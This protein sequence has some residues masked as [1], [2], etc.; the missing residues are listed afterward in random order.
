MLIY[1]FSF[2]YTR[3]VN[4]NKLAHYF[5]WYLVNSPE[6]FISRL[7]LPTRTL[8]TP[9]YCYFTLSVYNNATLAHSL[10]VSISL[11][12]SQASVWHSR[13]RAIWRY[14]TRGETGANQSAAY[15]WNSL[16]HTD[17]LQNRTLALID[18]LIL[19]NR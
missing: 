5:L 4:P 6:R 15:L 7:T 8:D 17:A 18:Q 16:Q 12:R 10:P 2:R 11:G 13:T 19:S 9:G 1:P 14:S 3:E